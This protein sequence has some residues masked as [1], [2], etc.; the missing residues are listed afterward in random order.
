MKLP[1]FDQNFTNRLKEMAENVQK[2][3]DS[4]SASGASGGDMVS[5]TLKANGEVLDF[6]ISDE[7]Y[8]LGSKE[9]LITLIKAAIADAMRNLEAAKK[10]KEFELA[11]KARDSF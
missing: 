11:T 9:M 8:N 5:I 7:A 10:E 3:L 1:F 4:I 6:N 2:E